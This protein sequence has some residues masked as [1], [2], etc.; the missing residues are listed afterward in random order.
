VVQGKG[1]KVIQVHLTAGHEDPIFMKMRSFEYV[2]V[3]KLKSLLWQ[4][5]QWIRKKEANQNLKIVTFSDTDFLKHLEMAITYGYPILFEDVDDF[6]DPVIENV[7]D[8]DI[9]GE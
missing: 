4:A 7:L 8:R 3:C 5:V 6:I 1:K 2:R 9:K